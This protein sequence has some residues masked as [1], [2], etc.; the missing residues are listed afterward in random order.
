[1]R[2][3]MFGEW[4][5]QF[6]AQLND[7]IPMKQHGHLRT[8]LAKLL[9]N[10]DGVIHSMKDHFQ[11]VAQYEAAKTVNR[12]ESIHKLNETNAKL[13]ETQDM[14]SLNTHNLGVLAK[15]LETIVDAITSVSST[16]NPT[17]QRTQSPDSA[18]IKPTFKRLEPKELDQL[19]F[20]VAALRQLTHDDL[21]AKQAVSDAQ[22]PSLATS[23]CYLSTC[24]HAEKV[25]R[26]LEHATI[27]L[28]LRQGQA[29]NPDIADFATKVVHDLADYTFLGSASTIMKERTS[30]ACHKNSPPPSPPSA[31]KPPPPCPMPVSSVKPNGI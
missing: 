20:D 25:E 10:F 13:M 11:I 1:M 7:D 2:H 12:T 31:P 4:T 18:D 28:N 26:A 30:P 21:V 15:Q 27:T 16:A 22:A 3:E 14:A 29:D 17:V 6:L 23:A 5:T 9:A 19:G 24:L 8:I